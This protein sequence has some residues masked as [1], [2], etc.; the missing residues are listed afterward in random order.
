MEDNDSRV[1]I[2]PMVTKILFTVLHRSV[3][4]IPAM[5]RTNCLSQTS[6][7]LWIRSL[8]SSKAIFG[9]CTEAQHDEQRRQ[10]IA[11]V[12]D[13][14]HHVLDD[15]FNDQDISPC[16]L[17]LTCSPLIDLPSIRLPLLL[18]FNLRSCGIFSSAPRPQH[19]SLHKEETQAQFSRQR[20]DVD[21]RLAFLHSLAACRQGLLLFLHLAGPQNRLFP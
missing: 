7:R 5:T 20:F 19:V 1:N 11:T 21:S 16:L 18:S 6:S 9:G 4:S 12:N 15:I 8:H 10:H 17:R 13:D 3:L 2:P 14:G